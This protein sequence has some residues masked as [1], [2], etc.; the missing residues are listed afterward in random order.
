M[1]YAEGCTVPR[2]AP[3]RGRGLQ[4][5][6]YQIDTALMAATF[7]LKEYQ[8][9]A[10]DRL[11]RLLRLTAAERGRA[12]RLYRTTKLPYRD[13]PQIAPRP[14]YP[15]VP[16][17]GGKTLLAAHAIGVAAR[18]FLQDP[19]PIVLWLVASTPILDQT[20]AALKTLGGDAWRSRATSAATCRS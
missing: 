9:A 17:G 3:R 2:K 20:V 8:Q 16:A 15:S 6:P 19:N 1:I 11:A 18:E 10:L 14:T 4:A 12:C 13:A 7:E 5:I